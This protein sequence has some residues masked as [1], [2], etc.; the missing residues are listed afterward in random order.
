MR[1]VKDGDKRAY[2]QLLDQQLPSVS[3]YVM[4][5]TGSNHEAEDIIQEVFLRLWTNAGRFDSEKAKL[6]T[7]L[8]NIAHNLCIDH[9]R[10]AGR[11]VGEEFM[12]ER[13]SCERP[14]TDLLDRSSASRVRDALMKIPERQRS[15]IVMCHF[16]ELSNKDAAS[17]MEVSVDALE[18]LLARG[19]RNLKTLLNTDE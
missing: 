10:K 8:H 4:R 17:V 11:L 1:Q 2:R 19:R 9:F 12:V 14:E 6:T 18:S 13:E 5:M 3:R 15:A 16:Q 7:W